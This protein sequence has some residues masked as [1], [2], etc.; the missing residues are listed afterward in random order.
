MVR[1]PSEMI[2][3]RAASRGA[4]LAL[5]AMLCLLLLKPVRAPVLGPSDAG[6]ATISAI[7][8]MS[9]PTPPPELPPHRARAELL[10][11][12]Q[13]PEASREG[14]ETASPVWLD[15]A[16][17]TVTFA[18]TKEYMRCL[19]AAIAHVQ[20]PGCPPPPRGPPLTGNGDVREAQQSEQLPRLTLYPH[21]SR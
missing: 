19:D 2:R 7:V 18:N 20:A 16:A 4:A 6:A 9:T 8:E 11:A 17:G 1:A 15:G 5:A 10:S 21:R 3:V 12:H 14:A 13:T